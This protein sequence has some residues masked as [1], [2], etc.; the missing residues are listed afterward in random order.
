MQNVEYRRASRILLASLVTMGMGFSVLFPLLAPIGREM[1]LRELQITSIIAASSLTVFLAMPFW[2]RLS[3]R[4]GRKRVMLI[5]MFGFAVGTI[6]FNSVLKLG[7]SGVLI[8][9]PLFVCLVAARVLHAAVMSATMPASTAYMADITD[10]STRTKGMGA[11]GAANNAGAIVGP[12]LSG[13]AFITLLTPLWLI[14]ALVFLNA[15]FVWRFLPESPR[16]S[17]GTSRSARMKYTD[18]RILPFVIVGV[19]MFMGFALVQQTMGFRFQD[20]LDLTTAETA[21]KF[22][23]AMM[24]SAGCSLFAQGVIVQRFTIAPFTLLKLAIPLLIVAFIL[25]A[26]FDTQLMLTVAMMIQGFGMGLAGPGFMAGASLAVSAE[27]QGAV[28]GVAGA[29]GPLGF[30]LGPLLGGAFY[31]LSPV[32]PYAFAAVVYVVLFAF[33]QW[34]GKRVTVHS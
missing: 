34:L 18:P 26:T 23:L 27:E 13:L 24:A 33:M 6:L 15:M 29:C 31:Q 21:Q 9:M 2:G 25:M 28:A 12:A 20:A 32:L 22:G 7:L 4:L 11:T 3:D 19:A 17:S 10:V 14:A 16:E 30:T 8:G 1:G 5:G